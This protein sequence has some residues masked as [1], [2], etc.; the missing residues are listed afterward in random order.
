MCDDCKPLPLRVPKIYESQPRQS[1]GMLVYSILLAT[2]LARQFDNMMTMRQTSSASCEIR[3]S[4][5]LADGQTGKVRVYMSVANLT[6]LELVCTSDYKA[7]KL[8]SACC[9]SFVD[10]IYAESQR[11]QSAFILGAKWA[12]PALARKGLD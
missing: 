1:I 5:L 8:C 7:E 9:Q 6:P 3:T 2:R 11:V 4:P 12:G 10:T